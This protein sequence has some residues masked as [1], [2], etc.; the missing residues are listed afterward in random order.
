MKNSDKNKLQIIQKKTSLLQI[1][2]Y[3]SLYV[4]N[5]L[6]H[7]KLYFKNQKKRILHFQSILSP[8]YQQHKNKEQY[9]NLQTILIGNK[10]KKT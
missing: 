3:Q 5:N 2:F 10:L 7:K 1:I 6:N 4:E 8:T 9:I